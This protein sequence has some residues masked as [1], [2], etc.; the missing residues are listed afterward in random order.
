MKS[1]EICA[2]YALQIRSKARIRTTTPF[3]SCRKFGPKPSHLHLSYLPA[4]FFDDKPFELFIIFPTV[5][6]MFR[7]MESHSHFRMKSYKMPVHCQPPSSNEALLPLPRHI[8]LN[9][10][11]LCALSW[12]FCSRLSM[13]QVSSSQN[14]FHALHFTCNKPENLYVEGFELKKYL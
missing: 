1:N 8:N 3:S 2:P 6:S 5:S 7:T 12:N 13:L 14:T 9:S 10:S 11:T 4:C